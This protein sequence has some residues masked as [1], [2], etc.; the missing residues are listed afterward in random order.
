MKSAAI[1]GIIILFILQI[2]SAAELDNYPVPFVSEGRF[3]ALL[4]VGDSSPAGDAL[5]ATDVA[6]HLQLSIEDKMPPAMLES[7]V[8]HPYAKNMILIG[9]CSVA[10]ISDVKNSNDCYDELAPGGGILELIDTNGVTVLIIGGS[11]TE[12]RRKAAR[13]LRYYDSVSF[14][15]NKIFVSGTIDEP[16]LGYEPIEQTVVPQEAPSV[17]E[18]RDCSVDD[19]CFA[20]EF[21]TR[22]GCVEVECPTGFYAKNHSCAKEVKEPPEIIEKIISATVPEQIEI[23]EQ[24]NTT[25]NETAVIVKTDDRNFLLR[26]LGWFIGLF[27]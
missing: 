10:L 17:T 5:A 1:F 11:N 22:F 24:P 8:I 9:D 13:A 20:K 14:Q 27:R 12:G 2:A 3:E 19:D 4:V 26:I 15:S 6:T 23:I 16:I 25:S 7:E 18:P 21:C